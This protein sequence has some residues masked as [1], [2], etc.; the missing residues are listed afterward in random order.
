MLYQDFKFPS[1]LKKKRARK[2]AV[3][4]LLQFSE[5]F[6][7]SFFFPT[8]IWTMQT[9]TIING[10]GVIGVTRAETLSSV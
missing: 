5:Q 6:Y 8:S 3:L 9:Q 1:F 7:D 10:E 4:Y 2:R